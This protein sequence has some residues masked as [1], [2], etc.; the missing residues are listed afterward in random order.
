MI[1][2]Q[3]FSVNTGRN[4]G[5]L[6]NFYAINTA[7]DKLN[8]AELLVNFTSVKEL[9]SLFVVVLLPTHGLIRLPNERKSLPRSS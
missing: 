2:N 1:A 4:Q 6:F 5:D 8:Q 9:V 3:T 7:Q